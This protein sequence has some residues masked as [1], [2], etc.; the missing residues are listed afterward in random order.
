MYS[1]HEHQ[2]KVAMFFQLTESADYICNSL[3]WAYEACDRLKTSCL[4]EV[5][6]D[7]SRN[8]LRPRQWCQM[9]N[10]CHGNQTI[11]G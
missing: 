6:Q 8:G 7:L 2:S 4:D 3:H 11:F 10:L 5:V 9:L 1:G